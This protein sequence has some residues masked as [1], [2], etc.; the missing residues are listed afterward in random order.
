MKKLEMSQEYFVEGPTDNKFITSFTR[1]RCHKFNP[2]LNPFRKIQPKI[3]KQCWAYLV[4]DMDLISVHHSTPSE[5]SAHKNCMKENLKLMSQQKHIVSI[6]LYLQYYELEDEWVTAST[7]KDRN[8]LNVLFSAAGKD[9][10]KKKI[11]SSKDLPSK[12]LQVDFK[13][14]DMWKQVLDE[15]RQFLEECIAISD[16]IYIHS[17]V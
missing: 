1:K 9:E 10:C 16:K 11:L 12:L 6:T 17:L 13:L 15:H 4:V 2:W 14:E 7:L 5:I 3:T 8:D